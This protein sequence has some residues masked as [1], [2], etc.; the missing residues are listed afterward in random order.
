MKSLTKATGRINNKLLM[1]SQGIM[2]AVAEE[3]AATIQMTAKSSKWRIWMTSTVLSLLLAPK[4]CVFVI[5]MG[6]QVQR[7]TLTAWSQP[8]PMSTCTKWTHSIQMTSRT[9]MPMVLPSHTSNF[10]EME[11]KLMKLL[12][13]P[14]GVTS[15]KSL[16]LLQSIM[17]VE[18]LALLVLIPQAMVKYTNWRTLANSTMQLRQQ[19]PRSWQFVTI[20]AVQLL[21]KVGTTWSHP[22]PMFTCIRWIHWM[23]TI[24]RSNMLMEP[25]SLTSNSII[26]DNSKMK[27]ST[28]LIGQIKNQ[29]SKMHVLATTLVL[30]LKHGAMLPVE[31]YI[32]SRISLNSTVPCL[33]LVLN[34]WLF[35]TTT[36]A[37]LRKMLGM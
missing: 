28:N 19:G 3:A 29:L 4:P 14:T 2:A 10:I 35:A 17:V 24:S 32:S 20:M 18:T 11:A 9:N 25:Q 34:T 22:T 31:K 8:T 12:T 6:A 16:M 23:Q 37:G 7:K 13:N 36:D 27:S 5:T 26:M 30:V 15:N 21:R 1:P 33:Q